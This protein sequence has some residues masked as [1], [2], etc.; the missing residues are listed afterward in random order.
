MFKMECQPLCYMFYLVS[1]V[2]I[3]FLKSVCFFLSF[4]SV[5]MCMSTQ[6][7]E[8]EG[9]RIWSRLQAEQGTLGQAPSHDPDM[10]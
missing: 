7:G 8:E 3:N 10:T 6:V 9:K 1:T 4:L 5:C 2:R